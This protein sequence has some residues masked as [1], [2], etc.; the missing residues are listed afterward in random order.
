[1]VD[2]ALQEVA[3]GRAEGLAVDHYVGLQLR[4]RHGVHGP[5][6]TGLV[7]GRSDLNIV[8]TSRHLQPCAGTFD[9]RFHFVGPSMSDRMEAGGFPWERVRHP[10]IVYASLGTLFNKDVA[11]YWSCFG[12]FQ[13]Q[14]LQVV[15]SIGSNVSADSLGPAPQNFIVQAHVPQ[16][17]VLRRAAMFITHGGM[18]SVNEGLYHGVPLVVIPQ[19]GEQQLVGRRVE[20]LGA[21]L[22]LAKEE[23]TPRKL[24]DAV[25]RILAEPG[26]RSQAAVV[27][28]SF[29]SAGGVERAADAIIAFTRR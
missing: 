1:V 22:Y 24:R 19:M 14:D 26:F 23:A 28:E 13:D 25:H 27:R 3:E 8:Y 29:L 18:N 10:V 15:L 16:L 7:L 9:E 20:E 2:H 12:A 21:G 5:G 6:L 17:E 4:R 11:F